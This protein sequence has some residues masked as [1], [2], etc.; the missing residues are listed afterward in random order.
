MTLTMEKPTLS[1]A[2]ISTLADILG[3]AAHHDR[4]L[5]EAHAQIERPDL[6]ELVA[7]RVNMYELWLVDFCA[8]IAPAAIARLDVLAPL[9]LG[10]KGSIPELR[11]EQ[12]ERFLAPI[13]KEAG[14][15][16]R[17]VGQARYE[18]ERVTL[19]S[20]RRYRFHFRIGAG[21][22]ADPATQPLS[23]AEQAEMLREHTDW[24]EIRQHGREIGRYR[25]THVGEE[26]VQGEAILEPG[27]ILPPFL[28]VDH[29]RSVGMSGNKPLFERRSIEV[30]PAVDSVEPLTESAES[31]RNESARN[32]DLDAMIS[33]ANAGDADAIAYLEANPELAFVDGLT[34]KW[35]V[36]MDSGPRSPG[37]SAHRDRIIRTRPPER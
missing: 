13:F 23:R 17:F 35:F 5:I 4:R 33:R 9:D 2:E 26:L 10:P 32:E 29:L 31:A 11:G 37:I 30:E 19:T 22:S 6:D 24:E 16:D 1:R 8:T 20:R 27:E 21:S 28:Q 25:Y 14:I 34:K 15:P 7:D 18:V 3:L 36:Q 12:L